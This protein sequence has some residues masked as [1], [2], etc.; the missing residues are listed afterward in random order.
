M[1]GPNPLAEAL[2]LLAA[3][4]RSDWLDVEVRAGDLEI[5]ISR[6]AP[7]T[8]APPRPDGP[9]MPQQ[10]LAP[11]VATVRELRPAGHS[12]D[13]GETIAVLEVLGDLVEIGAPARGRIERIAVAPGDL[14]EYGQVIAGFVAHR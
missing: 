9:Q 2:G 11:H 5:R 3:F 6:R 4:E 10:I 7:G 13:A 1:S 12:I 14:V 8:S